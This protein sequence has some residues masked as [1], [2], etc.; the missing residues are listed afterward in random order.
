MQ[1]DLDLAPPPVTAAVVQRQPTMT[2][3]IKLSIQISGRCQKEIRADLDIDPGQWS[4]IIG[5][6]AHFPHDRL[7]ALMDA[8]GNDIV[9]DW[10]AYQRGKDTVLREDEKDRRIRTL[11]E[12][13]DK[14]AAEYEAVKQ[15]IRDSGLR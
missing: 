2:A 13:V 15:F 14:Q 3:A 9:L 7:P 6:T 11:T 1:A 10:L 4:R 12:Q 5:G 8:T